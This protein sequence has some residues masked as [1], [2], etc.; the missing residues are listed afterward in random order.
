[1]HGFLQSIFGTKPHC[2]PR[3]HLSAPTLPSAIYAIGDVH[4][5]LALLHLLHKR[6]LA[7]C[8]DIPGEKWLV[9]LGDYV[10]RGPNSA[11]VL[12][13]LLSPLPSD[14]RKITLAG[15]HEIMMLEFLDN[16]APKSRW[17]QFGGTETLASY[18]ID[19]NALMARSKKDR[20]SLLASHIP[21]EHVELMR[22]LPLTLSVPGTV[23]V[24]AGL[25]P[26]VPVHQQSE[27]DA[28]WI[29]EQF[30][31]APAVE[32]RT[33]V[34]GHTPGADPVVEPGRICVD[35]GAFAT[36]VLTAAKLTPTEPIRFIRT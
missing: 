3:Q 16:P 29:R 31:T 6:I 19:A 2:P 10:D 26:G 21:T 13:E 33:V 27:D 4:G 11:G 20:Q 34:H 17:L 15:N 7:D 23:F 35:T 12:D 36:G 24:H 8:A 25:R 22:T 18:G 30:L 5:C 32:G 9:Y 28:L 1:M 14:V